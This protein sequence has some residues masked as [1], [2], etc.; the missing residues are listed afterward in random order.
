MRKSQLGSRSRFGRVRGTPRVINPWGKPLSQTSV[1]RTTATGQSTRKGRAPSGS[2]RVKSTPD[3]SLFGMSYKRNDPLAWPVEVPT[4]T[5]DLL[6]DKVTQD[7]ADFNNTV[8][9]AAFVRGGY[10]G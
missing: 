8:V 5:A 4:A 1:G 6:F 3:A 2:S 7:K 10:A 9:N